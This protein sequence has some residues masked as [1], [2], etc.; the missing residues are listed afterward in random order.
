[1]LPR[2]WPD[3]ASDPRNAKL[4]Y[5]RRVHLFPNGDL[6]AIYEGLG[7]VK[8]DARSKVLWAQRGGF[9]HDLSVTPQGEI[10]VLDREGKI[11]PRIHPEKGVLEDRVTV[12]GADGRLLRRISILEALERSPYASLLQ[13][14]ERE[15]DVFH[16]NTLDQVEIRNSIATEVKTLKKVLHHGPHLPKLPS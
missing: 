3:L 8:L 14:M 4:E 2:L 15:G 10:W 9:H 12:L 16:T 1:M 5:W 7:L 6:L 11:I 13:R